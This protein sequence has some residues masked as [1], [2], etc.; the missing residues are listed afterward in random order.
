MAPCCCCGRGFC[1]TCGPIVSPPR[2]HLDPRSKQFE[3]RFA[4]RLRH[5]LDEHEMGPSE[6]VERLRGVGVEVTVEAVKKWLSGDRLPYPGDV[7][8]IGKVLGLKDY[9]EVWP[10]P[11]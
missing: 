7:E 10:L 6:F 5:L 4:L 8:K 11:I 3:I 2:K 1:E 9:R